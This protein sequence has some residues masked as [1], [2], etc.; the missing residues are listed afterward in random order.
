MSDTSREARGERFDRAIDRAVREMLDV[1][2]PAGLRARVLERIDPSTHA[3]AS[4]FPWRFGWVAVPLAA[5]AV[6]VLAVLA[7]WR[8][9][10]RPSPAAPPP[11]ANAQ[12]T[13]IA[14]PPLAPTTPAPPAG[15]STVTPR[16]RTAQPERIAQAAG[17]RRTVQ[18]AAVGA[19]EDTNFTAVDALAGPAGFAVERLADPPAPPLRSIEPA[20]LQIPALEV[21]ALPETPRE[22]RE[23]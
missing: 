16:I 6:I 17:A 18:A 12:P 20:P 14:P 4:V 15:A 19:D 9:A 10:A 3:G 13:L 7:P 22:R 2:P 21:T 11:M 23:E 5:A 8:E 1:E